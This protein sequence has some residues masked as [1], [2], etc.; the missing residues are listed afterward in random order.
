VSHWLYG[1][2]L[3]GQVGFYAA[4]LVGYRQR[5]ARRRWF[6]FSVPCA[7]YLMSWATVFGF[8]RFLL[9]RQ[10]VTWERATSVAS[11]KGA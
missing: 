3:A 1:W 11:L 2:A 4:A 8:A 10:Q 9:H 5:Q 7:I 6:G